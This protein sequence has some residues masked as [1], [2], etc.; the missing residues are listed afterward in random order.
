[1][2][3]KANPGLKLRVLGGGSA[4][5]FQALAAGDADLGASSRK[6]KPE[7]ADAIKAKSGK[8]P[9][10]FKVALDGVAIFGNGNN[11]IEELTVAQLADILSGK[12]T[13]WSKVGGKDLP[14]KVYSRDSNSGTFA[15]VKEH[16]LKGQDFVS[17]A[18]TLSGNLIVS[19]IAADAGGIGY[20]SIEL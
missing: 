4:T 8:E 2:F 18:A 20:G 6:I 3:G 10:E 16:V 9:A 15:F 19:K 1:D 13:N 5:G 12:I 7:E 14:I 11:P 17:S